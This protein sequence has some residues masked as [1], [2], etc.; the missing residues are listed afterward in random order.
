MKQIC[1]WATESKSHAAM[2]L[3]AA[4]MVYA[5]AINTYG[6]TQSDDRGLFTGY[7]EDV[8]RRYYPPE[9]IIARANLQNPLNCGLDAL[10]S[11]HAVLRLHGDLKQTEDDPRTL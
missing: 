9:G 11:P 2:A 7:N 10:F 3:S 4:F 8:P 5:M 6:I 1:E